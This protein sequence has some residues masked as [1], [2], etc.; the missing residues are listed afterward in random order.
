MK[1]AIV[2]RQL[3]NAK[4]SAAL[5]TNAIRHSLAVSQAECQAEQLRIYGAFT[6]QSISSGV[7]FA[8]AA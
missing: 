1:S 7:N 2:E 4:V 6:L 5:A 3:G 8:I